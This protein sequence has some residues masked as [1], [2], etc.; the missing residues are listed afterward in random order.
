M[1]LYDLAALAAAA[2]WALGGILAAAPS[3]H[4]G[5]FTFTRLRLTLLT[6]L[7]GFISWI[8]GGWL[9]ISAA[10]LLP[11]VLSG[12]VGIFLGDTIYFAAMNR[13]GPRKSGLL[14][15]THSVFSVFLGILL[16][17]ERLTLLSALG[18]L[19]VFGGVLLA[20]AFSRRKETEYYAPENNAH[21]KCGVILGL[22]SALCQA[23][24][25]FF[26]KPAMDL[27]LDP[28]TASA[29]RM[30]VSCLAHYVL[31][32]CGV[33]IAASRGQ[34]TIRMLWLT[35]LNGIVAMGL[36]MTLIMIALQK[37]NVATVGMLSALS[38]VL[39]LPMLWFITKKPPTPL[40]WL[41]AFMSC[42][43]SALIVLR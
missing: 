30:G 22:L 5:P 19:M 23:F 15:A 36:G 9:S 28:V 21:F 3:R 26:A 1:L 6:V 11:I 13:L 7:L 34:Y 32:I 8:S 33:K 41:G 17:G 31:L 4:F 43:G 35:G 12:I 42:A 16:L 39:I 38:P 24:G 40:A 25:T 14:F 10:N 18:S 37:S 20:V 27:K 29:L 2:C